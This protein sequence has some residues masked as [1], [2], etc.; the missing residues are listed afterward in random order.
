MPPEKDP[1][2]ED[3]VLIFDTSLLDIEETTMNPGD[4]TFYVDNNS[5]EALKICANG[6]F[7]V[8]GKKVKNDIEVYNGFVNFLKEAGHYDKS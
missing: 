7:L 8:H 5:V 3:Q 2:N 6:D 4:I 1:N